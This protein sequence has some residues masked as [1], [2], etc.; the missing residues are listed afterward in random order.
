[1]HSLNHYYLFKVLR[2]TAVFFLA[3]WAWG[4]ED[5]DESG[6]GTD[7]GKVLNISG[8]IEQECLTRVD[9]GGFADGDCMGVFV[10]DYEEIYMVSKLKTK[11]KDILLKRTKGKGSFVYYGKS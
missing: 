10:V 9:D 1:M 6:P 3:C 2:F 11:H 4:C 8:R 5:H 7:S